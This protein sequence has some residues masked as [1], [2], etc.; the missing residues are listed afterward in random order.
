MKSND[1]G[2]L[3]RRSGQL[4]ISQEQVVVRNPVET[5]APDLV[6]QRKLPR[7]CVEPR[8]LGDG[9]VEPGIEYGYRRNRCPQPPAP[10]SNYG[11]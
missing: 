4:G 11:S 8:A 7:D 3:W 5:M 6:P 9:T 10:G 2:L 1:V